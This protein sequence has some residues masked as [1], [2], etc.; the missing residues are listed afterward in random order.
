MFPLHDKVPPPAPIRSQKY[1]KESTRARTLFRGYLELRFD[2]LSNYASTYYRIMLR[3]TVE[4]C[5]DVL[6]NYAST[7]CRIML[8]RRTGVLYRTNS[9]G[10]PSAGVRDGWVRKDSAARPHASRFLDG[11]RASIIVVAGEQE[12]RH[13]GVPVPLP[14]ETAYKKQ[15][16]S[17][18]KAQ[19]VP[20]SRVL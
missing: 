4:L 2:A 12:N 5:F 19:G 7:Y 8:R 6:S 17:A 20:L 1:C 14:D 16:P 3:R 15:E 9:T 13:A 10:R 11:K 18:P